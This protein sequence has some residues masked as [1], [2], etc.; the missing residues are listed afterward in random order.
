MS[1]KKNNNNKWA[2]DENRTNLLKEMY[3]KCIVGKDDAQ[4]NVFIEKPH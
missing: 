4:C 3:V 1:I 2:K